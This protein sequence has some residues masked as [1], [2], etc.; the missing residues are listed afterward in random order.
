VSLHVE[1]LVDGQQ[2]LFEDESTRTLLD[3]L[4]AD[5]RLYRRS[6][7]YKDLLSFVVR[8]REF[9]PFNAMLLQVQKPGLSYAASEKD[10]WLRFRRRPKEG[11]RPL[12]I[13]WPFGPVALVYDVMDTEGDTLPEDVSSFVARGKIGREQL[14]SFEALLS[15][16]SIK[17]SWVD[18]GD[19]S[20]GLIR[21]VRRA[22]DDSGVTQYRININQNHEAAVQFSTLAHELGHLFLGHLGPDKKLSIPR[23]RRLE[24][25]KQ[26][27]EAESV[28]YIVCQ[29]NGIEPKSQTYLS[30]FVGADTSLGDVDVYQ[31]MRAAGQVET[32]LNIATRS[33]FD[34]PGR[35]VTTK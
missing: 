34:Q 28:A 27:I 21:V 29:R 13:L 6:A 8:L 17:L 3:Q 14:I 16:K 4:L 32:L 30:A 22:S 2:D 18:A 15:R 31:V 12:L 33:R 7:D 23:R 1:D 9:A 25:D 10:W 5:S 20:A 26:E 11:A 19:R 35:P 24:H